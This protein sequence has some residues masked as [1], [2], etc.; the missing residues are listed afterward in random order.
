M[1]KYKIKIVIEGENGEVLKTR[2][3]E[4]K[5]RDN[6]FNDIDLEVYKF[7]NE[8]IPE[9]SENIFELEQ[10]EYKKNKKK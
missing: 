8:I 9:I 1:S 7:K 3:K 2:E 4:I 10:T 6:N 5:V